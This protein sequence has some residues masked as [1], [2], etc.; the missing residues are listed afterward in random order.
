VVFKWEV[1]KTSLRPVKNHSAV[2]ADGDI[3]VKLWAVIL[4]LN[5][6]AITPDRHPAE[7]MNYDVF[8]FVH[9]K[10]ARRERPLKC[11]AW[12][13]RLHLFGALFLSLS[14]FP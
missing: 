13:N 6:A 4:A 8:S 11:F 12:I 1:M 7:K 9:W 3:S 2:V 14:L 5:N 10:S